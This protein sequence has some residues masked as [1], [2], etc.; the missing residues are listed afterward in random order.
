M[1][2]WNYWNGKKV[3]IILKNRRQYSGEVVDVDLSAKPIIFISIIDKFN[4]RVTFAQSE[5]DVMQEEEK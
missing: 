3:F 5:I 2:G 1:E 4:N